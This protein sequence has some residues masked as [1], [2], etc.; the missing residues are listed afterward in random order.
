MFA[1]MER[2]V[3]IRI[4]ALVECRAGAVKVGEIVKVTPRQRIPEARDVAKGRNC[5]KRKRDD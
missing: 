5:Q 2:L 3:A 1:P 4:G